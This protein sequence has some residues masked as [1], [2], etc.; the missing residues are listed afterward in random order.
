MIWTS[1]QIIWALTL[2]G[3]RE[4]GRRLIRAAE[5]PPGGLADH[6]RRLTSQPAIQLRLAG[7]ET[8]LAGLAEL[9]YREFFS[10]ILPLYAQVGIGEAASAIASYQSFEGAPEALAA[11]REAYQDDDLLSSLPFEV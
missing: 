7:Q 1:G 6:L 10:V 4:L 2:H 8:V 5:R 11:L 3:Q 9:H